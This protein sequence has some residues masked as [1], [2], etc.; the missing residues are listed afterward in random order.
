MRKNPTDERLK[1]QA[2]ETKIKVRSLSII[3]S[4]KQKIEELTNYAKSQQNQSENIE[5]QIDVYEC[6]DFEEEEEEE[7]KSSE[8]IIGNY[9]NEIMENAVQM[10]ECFEK[11]LVRIC[12]LLNSLKNDLSI[13][14][15]NEVNGE[16][17]L[18][19]K[20]KEEVL[21]SIDNDLI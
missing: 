20:T 16:H 8:S 10:P 5:L 2:A 7:M 4:V 21:K 6:Q 18:K 13:S 1:S 19:I 17:I 11:S 12:Y 14:D 3:L 15:E 9:C